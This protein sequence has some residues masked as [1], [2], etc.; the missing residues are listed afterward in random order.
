MSSKASRFSKGFTLIEMIFVIA[1]IAV[2]AAIIAPLAVNMISD[3]EDA[4]VQADIEA[5]SAALTRFKG[6]T[7]FW[8]ASKGTSTTT[9]DQSVVEIYVGSGQSTLPAGSNP[10]QATGNTTW[11]LT[12]ANFT[13]FDNAFNHFAIN[14]PNGDGTQNGATD[15]KSSG[16]K[17][18]K[19]PYLT[20]FTTDPFGKNYV[21]NVGGIVVGGAGTGATQGGQGW[22]I[23]A[24]RNN[25]MDTRR[26]ATI[27]SGDD[28]GVLY[29]TK[30]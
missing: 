12:E 2:I 10:T 7:G 17:R 21:L 20:K 4:R 6:D 28:Q 16:N 11:S 15:Y 22:I 18:W 25:V 26:T 19:G 3:A 9:T 13:T 23:S 27:L 14:D 1:V 29:C 30:C 24:G 8:P 5:I